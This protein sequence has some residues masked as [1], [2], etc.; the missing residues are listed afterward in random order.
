MTGS[1]CLAFGSPLII[2]S[3]SYQLHFGKL[4]EDIYLLVL[5]ALHPEIFCRFYE[6]L[7]ER[8]LKVRPV[9]LRQTLA[10]LHNKSLDLVDRIAVLL[11][12]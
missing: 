11:A 5:G 7:I 10:M 1:L 4:Q 12:G 6:N 3:S 2:F 8:R 9:A